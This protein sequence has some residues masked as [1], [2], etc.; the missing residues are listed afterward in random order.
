MPVIKGKDYGS[1]HINKK[2]LPTPRACDGLSSG[3]TDA[4]FSGIG[5]YRINKKGERFG[6]R[7][8]DAVYAITHLNKN[9]KCDSKNTLSLKPKSEKDGLN[10]DWVEWLMHMPIGWTD[11]K[12]LKELIW[13]DPLIDPHPK[14]KRTTQNKVNRS[15]RLKG[16]GNAQY[17]LTVYYVWRILFLKKTF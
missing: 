12:E 10:P 1:L 16:I 11:I 3:I 15:S 14:L 8:A 9:K 6:V 2:N 7:L 13:L 4:L 5:W 17:C